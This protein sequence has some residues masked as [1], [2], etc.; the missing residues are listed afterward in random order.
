MV[1][2]SKNLISWKD[3]RKKLG[4]THSTN[5]TGDVT[6]L[7]TDRVNYLISVYLVLLPAL[8]GWA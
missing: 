6:A 7:L 5:K 4:E 3:N 8:R 1:S 2:K